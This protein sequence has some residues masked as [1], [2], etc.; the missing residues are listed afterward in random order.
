MGYYLLGFGIN[1]K[2]FKST[3]HEKQSFKSAAGGR[4]AA[5]RL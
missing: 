2:P 5:G 4:Y 3:H 1:T